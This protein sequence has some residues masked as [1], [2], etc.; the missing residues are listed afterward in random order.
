VPVDFVAKRQRRTVC[1]DQDQPPGV[2]IAAHRFEPLGDRAGE[3]LRRVA[4]E[5]GSGHRLGERRQHPLLLALEQR[6]Q[7]L[8]LVAE[9]VVDDGFRDLGLTGYALHRHAGVALLGDQLQG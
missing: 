5:W 7:Q 2:G 3:D 1:R 4:R 8:A 9:G 6:L